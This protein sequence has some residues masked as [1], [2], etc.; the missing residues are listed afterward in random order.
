MSRIKF[1]R[2]KQREFL[3][4]VIVN[5]NSPSLRRLNQFGIDIKYNSMKAYYNETRT[6]PESLF[7]DLCKL[8][9]INSSSLNIKI[10]DENWGQKLGGSK[11]SI[12]A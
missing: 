5:S 8:A 9:G 1:S 4:K 11:Y 7:L 2:G 10:I 3:R 12:S 6:L